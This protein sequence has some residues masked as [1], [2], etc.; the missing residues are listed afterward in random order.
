[1]RQR[2]SV[3][4]AENLENTGGLVTRPKNLEVRLC[5]GAGASGSRVV[6]VFKFT[7]QSVAGL[8]IS[9]KMLD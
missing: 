6:R 4:L 2:E 8:H 1:M 5:K 9:S 3:K 7:G